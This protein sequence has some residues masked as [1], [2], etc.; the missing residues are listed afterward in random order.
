MKFIA[1][2][3]ILSNEARKVNNDGS[4]FSHRIYGLVQSF[5][6]DSHLIASNGVDEAAALNDCLRT[7]KHQVYFVHNI[8]HCRV[9]DDCAW[10]PCCAQS[11]LCPDTET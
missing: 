4:P 2:G 1:K 7:D 6:D 10:N 11:L 5:G 8:S 9:E 3:A